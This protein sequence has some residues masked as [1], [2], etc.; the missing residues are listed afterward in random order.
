[1]TH[2]V[3]KSRK[4]SH[5][6]YIN[7]KFIRIHFIFLITSIFFIETIFNPYRSSHELDNVL[8]TQEQIVS[9]FYKLIL[10]KYNFG[11]LQ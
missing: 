10:D 4:V 3:T 6:Q 8:N 2:K 11:I 1:M 5:S 7:G 9:M